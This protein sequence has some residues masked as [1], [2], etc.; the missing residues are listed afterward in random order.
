[1]PGPVIRNYKPGAIIYFEKDKAEDIYVLQ[2]GKIMLTYMSVDG[3]SEIKED[4]KLGEFFGVKSS[5]G[6]FPREETAQ[7]LTNSNVLVFK[8]SEFEKFVGNKTHLII[9]MMKVFSN[10]LR[11][12]HHKVREQLGQ[13]GE[14]KSPAF[15]ML[16]VGEVFHKNEKYNHAGYVYSR[17][18]SYYPDGNYVERAKE[19]LDLANNSTPFPSHLGDLQYEPEKKNKKP[20]EGNSGLKMFE[21]KANMSFKEGKYEEASNV[22]KSLMDNSTPKS[23][24]EQTIIENALFYYAMCMK[25]L[26]RIDEASTNF[27][28]YVKKYPKGALVK[29]SILNL[30]SISENKG[31]KDKAINLY[32]KVLTIEPQDEHSETAK[33]QIAKLKGE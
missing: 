3:K 11:Q 25:E 26:K 12:I 30:A 13:Y 31:E 18:L 7:S 1:L 22:F 16:N 14:A 24:Q 23:T 6:R 32:N 21:D 19:L 2:S 4:V 28:N 5:L 27:T 15:E 17:Y 33:T 29:Q 9:K 20:Q 8:S 10:Q